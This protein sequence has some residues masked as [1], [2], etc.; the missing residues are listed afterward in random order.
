MTAR[1]SQNSKKID[2]VVSI[3][4]SFH[5]I[6]FLVAVSVVVAA[7]SGALA[8]WC[9]GFDAC[10]GF[11]LHLKGGIWQGWIG[12]EIVLKSSTVYEPTG[13]YSQPTLTHFKTTTRRFA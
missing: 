6:A 7:G 3:W 11:L 2:M 13:S 12:L 5:V 8:F 4:L 1:N 10:F 9:A